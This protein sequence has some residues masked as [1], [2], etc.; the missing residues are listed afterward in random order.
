MPAENDI[1][2][3]WAIPSNYVTPTDRGRH[4]IG[5]RADSDN[6]TRPKPNNIFIGGSKRDLTLRA[7]NQAWT[8]DILIDYYETDP[9]GDIVVSTGAD[10]TYS[11]RA[12]YDDD[13]YLN[14]TRS[15]RKET[16]TGFTQEQLAKASPLI[17]EALMNHGLGQNIEIVTA[18]VAPTADQMP[19]LRRILAVPGQTPL[20]QYLGPGVAQTITNRFRAHVRVNI[21][22]VFQ[23]GPA[24][25]GMGQ[26]TVN[27]AE[28][29]K[30]FI[31]YIHV[32]S[33]PN[34]LTIAIR[35]EALETP[36]PSPIPSDFYLD[37]GS[38]GTVHPTDSDPRQANAPTIQLSGL[39]FKLYTIALTQP[40]YNA[41]YNGT[42]LD[43]N[44]DLQ[45]SQRYN[46]R[47]ASVPTANRWYTITEQDD[48]PPQATVNTESDTCLLYTSPSPRD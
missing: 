9:L 13:T 3:Y 44:K 36:S 5:V 37:I 17:V 10:E 42:D 15:L 31:G 6:E 41:F 26:A 25:V 40:Q 2:E 30:A 16:I 28:D 32:Q 4:V 18:D 33:S 34:T 27:T 14:A 11:V 29:G 1:L 46:W 38:L 48:I 7:G 12:Q 35:A 23:I 47:A 24:G 20:L 43:F 8:G 19:G 39:T 21:E 45:G 22:G